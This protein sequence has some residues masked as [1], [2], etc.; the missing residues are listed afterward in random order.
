M[1]KH[2]ALNNKSASSDNPHRN[3]GAKQGLRSKSTIMRLN[4]YKRGKPVRTKDGKVVGGTLMMDNKAGGKDLPS[5]ARIAPDRRWFG[6]TRT[7]SQTDLDKFREEM[8]LKQADPYSVV[9][10]RKKI[11]MALLK[12]SSDKIASINLAETE[13]YDS[14]F[15]SKMT[16]KKPKLSDSLS[17]YASLMSSVSEKSIAYIE[18]GTDD[19]L[20]DMEDGEGTSSLRKDDLFS[21]GQSKRIWGEL[22]KVMDCSDVILEIVDARNVP[23]TRCQHVEKH[24]K[25]NASHKHV[26]III[27]KCDLVPSWVTRKWVKILS[28]DFPTLAFHASVTNSFGKGALISLLRQFGK[29]HADK[30]QI[31]VGVIGYPNVGKS[32]VINTLMGKK[33]CKAAPVPGETKVWQYITLMRR[34][35]LIDSPGIVYNVGDDEVETVLKGVVRA[36]RLETPTDFIAPILDRVRP[37]YIA[38]FYQIA[39]WTD[40]TDFLNKVAQ[41]NGKLLKGGEF[42]VH[43]IAINV[44]NDWQ[45]GKLPYFVAPP[46]IAGEVEGVEEDEGEEEEGNIGLDAFIADTKANAARKA[47][48]KDPTKAVTTGDEEEDEDSEEGFDGSEGES[49]DEEEEVHV[50]SGSAAVSW[51]DI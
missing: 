46:Q 41:H 5:V 8:T 31:S 14:T 19:D 10:R 45:R 38:K 37:E 12:E 16:R 3:P 27:N 23:G 30:R 2:A 17:D 28:K 11:P 29:L 51:D 4:M 44:I 32:S 49:E 43:G 33:C 25:K 18:K 1:T 20:A 21:K 22:Y 24:V 34:I 7:V 40:A 26:I 36:E 47:A 9:L 15:G 6:N 39:E 50:A 13:S 42:D 35:F 48:S